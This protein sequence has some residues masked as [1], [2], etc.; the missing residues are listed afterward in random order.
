MFDFLRNLKVLAEEGETSV[1]ESLTLDES[2]LEPLPKTDTDT[3]LTNVINLV[4]FLV[5]ALAVVMIIYSGFQLVTSAGNPGAVAKAK[6]TLIY[7]I[8][9]LF[10]TVAAYAIVNYVV[11]LF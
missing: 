10:L 8:V 4:F 2:V 1:V 9:G 6:N 3:I 11:D 5:G 7:S